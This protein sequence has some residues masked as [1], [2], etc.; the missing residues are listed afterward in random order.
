[1]T[2]ARPNW[3]A[4]CGTTARSAAPSRTCRCQSS[5]R[6]IVSSCATRRLSHR[7]RGAS[8]RVA[9]E[10]AHD[11]RRA[12]LDAELLVDALQV[13]MHRA[14]AAADDRAD[15]AVGLA[16]AEPPDDLPLARC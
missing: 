3:R 7:W 12:R 10:P 2:I 1:M 9:A 13:L 8:V 14:M 15:V 16:G 5:G 6:V 11:C 4:L